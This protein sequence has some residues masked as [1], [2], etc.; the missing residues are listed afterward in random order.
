MLAR[1]IKN[2]CKDSLVYVVD[3]LNVN[4]FLP[5]ECVHVL[6][7]FVAAVMYYMDASILYKFADYLQTIGQYFL[8]STVP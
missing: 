8:L 7:L 6:L 5:T 2:D 1:P 3:G 4:I